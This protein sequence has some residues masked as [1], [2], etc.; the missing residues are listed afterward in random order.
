[1]TFVDQSADSNIVL[2]LTALHEEKGAT[3]V[4]LVKDSKAVLTP[5][6]ISGTSGNNVLV[7][8]GVSVGDTIV[9]AGVHFLSEGQQVRLM[10]AS[11]QAN[12]EQE[13]AK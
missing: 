3:V 12:A 8:Q 13:A 4:W 9:V 7:S 1:V 5:V 2:P 10:G 11:K 6:T